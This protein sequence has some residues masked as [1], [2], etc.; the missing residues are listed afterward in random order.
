K[1]R[2]AEAP[3]RQ[4]ENAVFPVRSYLL[5]SA[6]TSSITPLGSSTRKGP[7]LRTVIVT[8]AMKPPVKMNSFQ[9]IVQEKKL[10]VLR[11]PP[12]VHPFKP[13][14]LQPLIKSCFCPFPVR[15]P[16]CAE[17]RRITGR[18]HVDLVLRQAMAEDQQGAAGVEFGGHD[19]QSMRV[20]RLQATAHVFGFRVG[21]VAN[22]RT[23]RDATSFT[24]T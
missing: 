15:P 21:R 12:P 18:G 3:Q 24:E 13:Q 7:F 22:N 1:G 14:H 5:P 19:Q 17:F 20:D 8:C 2:L 11:L 9:T 6:S 16:G 4:S 10:P 23:N